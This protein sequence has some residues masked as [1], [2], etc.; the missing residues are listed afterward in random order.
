MTHSELVA[1]AVRWLKGSMQCSVVL[2]EV[3][4]IGREI[5]DAIGWSYG[6]RAS[7]LV[8]CKTSKSD[9][10][11]DIRHKYWH[12]PECGVGLFRYFMTPPDLVRPEE[13]PEPWGLLE[14]HPTQVR[15]KRKAKSRTNEY[16]ER[17]R[18]REIQDHASDAGN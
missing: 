12:R 4:G 9:L 6:G 5:P 14:V 3:Q 11:A 8:E 18:T 7:I 2:A 13:L 17:I 1:R 16:G 10:V 15:V